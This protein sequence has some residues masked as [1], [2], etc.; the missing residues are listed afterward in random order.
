MRA[1]LLPGF[2]SLCLLLASPAHAQGA[3]PSHADRDAIRSVI[4][5]QLEAFRRDDAA[6]A[7]AEAAPGIRQMF[8]TPE[9][10]LDMVRR[11]YPPVYRPRSAEFTRLDTE[12]G[13]VVQ[14]VEIVGP[15]GE[16]HT[17]I[18]TM[19]REPDGTWRI[20]GCVLTQGV[21]VGT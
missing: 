19:E 20:A 14:H 10:F 15:D 21:R 13:Q 4:Q 16:T 6:G 3:A 5:A 9:I 2:L 8:P 1:L 7:Y 12:D 11:G 17:A 18:Y